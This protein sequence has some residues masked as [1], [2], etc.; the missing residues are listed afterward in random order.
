MH[1]CHSILFSF[2]LLLA[3]QSSQNSSR[4]FAAIEI[5]FKLFYCAT[6]GAVQF[7]IGFVKYKFD[8]RDSCG[9]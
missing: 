1:A 8:K 6:S 7:T 2:L 5:V 4:G 3:L 9:T